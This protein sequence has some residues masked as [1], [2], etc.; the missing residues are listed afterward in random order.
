M[1]NFHN[2]EE[3]VKFLGLSERYRPKHVCDTWRKVPSNWKER[4]EQLFEVYSGKIPP[5]FFR[6]DDVG[7][8][9]QGLRALMKLFEYHN[10]PLAV[11]VVPA[12]LNAKRLE[13]I[14]EN[15][16]ISS[17]LWTWHQHGWRHVNWSTDGKKAE[18]CRS[19]TREQQWTDIMKGKMKLEDLLGRHFVP[20]FT[21]PWN[22]L[23][24]TTLEVLQRL[25]FKG[26][27]LDGP[28]PRG[29]KHS[30]KLKNFRIALDMHTR[31][32]VQKEFAFDEFMK[33]LE[34]LFT[35]K[36]PVGIMIHHHR[37]NIQAFEILNLI[38]K[39][40]KE[41]SKSCCLSIKEVV[42]NERS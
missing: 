30:I 36:G 33:D 24:L 38:L 14:A 40:I 15:V 42:Q 2:R 11:A 3:L 37:M 19:R 5:L 13:K 28:F 34:A 16:D 26:V 25:D 18:F 35:Q 17:P 39:L 29:A 8:W 10:V 20:V 12:W 1:N 21:P 4:L 32:S 7:A 6:A 27:S 23:D 31:K 9:G 22:R 41:H